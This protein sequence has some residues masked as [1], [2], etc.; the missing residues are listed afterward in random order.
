MENK[1][2]QRLLVPK[3]TLMLR[4]I[5]GGYL[6]YTSYSLIEAIT[7]T[8]GKEQL[9]FILATA[10]FTI[11]GIICIFFSVRSFSR[12]EYQGGSADTSVVEEDV[13]ESEVIDAGS[14]EVDAIEAVDEEELTEADEKNVNEV[15]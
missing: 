15:E 6:L 5:I 13:I 7:T 11:V 8:T 14:K 10:V 4:I 9:L 1:K 3:F 12:G 2:R